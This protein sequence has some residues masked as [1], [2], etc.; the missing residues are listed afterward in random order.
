MDLK[1]RL[2]V[3][4]VNWN[5][6]D[7]LKTCLKSAYDTIRSSFEIIVVD[8]N[9]S[10]N[11]RV[12]I[13]RDFPG[14]KLIEENENLGYS[15]A[16]NV[17]FK[18]SSGEY[19]LVLNPD[20]V[21]LDKAVDK[22]LSFLDSHADVRIA[23]PTIYDMKKGISKDARKNLPT[24]FSDFLELFLL[25]KVA[26]IFLDF[27]SKNI[28][29]RNLI[30]SKYLKSGECECI[31]GSC[32]FFRRDDIVSL[33]GF[34]ESIPMYLDDVDICKRALE[35][36][37]KIYYFS[38]AAIIHIEHYSTRKVLG[39]KMYDILVLKARAFYY[40]KHYGNRALFFYRTM[41]FL[42]IPY[43]LM[44]DALTMPYFAVLGRLNEKLWVLKK[45]VSYFKVLFFKGTTINLDAVPYR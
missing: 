31:S 9:S 14:V 35:N 30:Y 12:M 8:N 20:T 26:V 45:H 1:V 22:M 38:E 25:K 16:N 18:R 15:K 21:L 7:V 11:S 32:M 34:D 24:L 23:G 5:A 4:I 29:L 19:I 13:K 43:L 40:R 37:W 44:L 36:G 2:S 41:V 39:Y 33:G 27:I 28:V 6:A 10:D 42:S 3:I 17:G